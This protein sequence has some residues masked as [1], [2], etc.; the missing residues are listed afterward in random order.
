MPRTRREAR[1][2]M[3]ESDKIPQI[4][5]SE[6]E[7]LIQKIE[8]NKLRAARRAGICDGPPFLYLIFI[9]AIFTTPWPD[10]TKKIFSPNPVP[11]I[12]WRSHSTIYRKASASRLDETSPLAGEHKSRHNRLE[13][14][15]PRYFTP[16]RY[17]SSA[18]LS[19]L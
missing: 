8:Q 19:R 15:E 13:E 2:K 14:I 12:S 5:P 16:V 9:F 18:I 1:K 6:I 10:N 17:F 7:V 3:V 11:R 4:D